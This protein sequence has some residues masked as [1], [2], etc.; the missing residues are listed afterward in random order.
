MFL[1][2]DIEN[3]I[4]KEPILTLII[5]IFFIYTIIKVLIV[6]LKKYGL[7]TIE[8]GRD[9]SWYNWLSIFNIWIS[10]A[11]VLLVFVLGDTYSTLTI[12]ERVLSAIILLDALLAFNIHNHLL[13]YKSYTVGMMKHIEYIEVRKQYSRQAIYLLLI[14]LLV[15][16]TF[17]LDLLIY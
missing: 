1:L 12:I 14:W 3:I 2:T 7:V 16:L 10:L 13:E 5:L 8:L 11:F 6:I 15:V 9:Y 17:N 4:L